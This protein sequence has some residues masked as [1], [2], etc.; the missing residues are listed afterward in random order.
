MSNVRISGIEN[1]N[2]VRWKN[3]EIDIT[4]VTTIFVCNSEHIVNTCMIC[5]SK[6]LYF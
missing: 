3:I 2:F 6:L 5:F 1:S 4:M